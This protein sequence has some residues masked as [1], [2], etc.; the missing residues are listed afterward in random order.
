MT[1]GSSF[2]RLA[3]HGMQCLLDTFG[4]AR[5][6]GEVG[7]SRLVGP[8]AALFPIAQGAKRDVVARGKFLLG[9]RQGAAEGLNTRYRTQLACL[10][11]GEWWGVTVARRAV[12][13]SATLIRTR[14][15]V[16][17]A[18]SAPP[19]LARTSLPLRRILAVVEV[20]LVFCRPVGE[21]SQEEREA[22]TGVLGSSATFTDSRRE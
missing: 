15:G 21:G 7:S 14:D 8:R 20:L 17:S 13:I 19:G 16:A 3:G 5:D 18:S 1:G 4:I 6:D 11:L 9:Q 10:R 12:S 22:Q 2:R